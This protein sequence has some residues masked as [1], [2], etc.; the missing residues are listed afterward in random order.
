MPAAPRL[1][2][3]IE[4][5]IRG[6]QHSAGRSSVVISQRY[7]RERAS[8]LSRLAEEAVVT[9]LAGQ[10]AGIDLEG[11]AGL[12][13][14]ARRPA[15][16]APVGGIVKRLAIGT[17]DRHGKGTPS[18]ASGQACPGSEQEGPRARRAVPADP[19]DMKAL[20]QPGAG[21]RGRAGCGKG[22]TARLRAA[23]FRTSECS[24]GASGPVRGER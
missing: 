20:A 18:R 11:G 7:C 22:A 12:A 15:Q 4:V 5:V 1:Q 2:H 23:R 16:I 6:V 17:P 21:R 8:R 9:R 10:L 19:A 14:R 3:I 13:A 24:G